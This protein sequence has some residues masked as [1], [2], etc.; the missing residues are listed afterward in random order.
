MPPPMRHT[1]SRCDGDSLHCSIRFGA[2]FRLTVAIVLFSVLLSLTACGYRFTGGGYFPADVQRIFIT[3]FDNKTSEIGVENALATA[4]TRE[5]T[6]RANASAVA[7][8]RSSADAV[9][10]GAITSIRIA[11]IARSSE[12]VSDEARLVITVN[13]RL[14]ANGGGEIWATNAVTATETYKIQQNDNQF[15]ESSKNAAL[16]RA[17]VRLAEQLYSR[18]VQNF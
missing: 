1:G 6:T 8:S 18:L 5:F 16:D 15:T 2:S 14:T 3:I 13:A 7:A 11:P 9:L 10:S 12:T 4:V 17:A